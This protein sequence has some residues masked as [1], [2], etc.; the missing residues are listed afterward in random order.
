MDVSVV[1]L[2]ISTDGDGRRGVSYA[3]ELSCIEA[4]IGVFI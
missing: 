2:P 1:R 3:G 4:E